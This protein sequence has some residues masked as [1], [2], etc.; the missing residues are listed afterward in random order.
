[1]IETDKVTIDIR[2]ADSGVITQMFAADGAKV[3][4]GKPFYEIDTSAAKPAG[5]AAAPETK[6]EEKKE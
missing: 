2:C 6:K 3:E 1:M 5:G 4:V